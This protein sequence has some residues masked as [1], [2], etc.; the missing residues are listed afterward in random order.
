MRILRYL[1]A[2]IAVLGIGFFLVGVL[3]PRFSYANEVNIN[4]SPA[5]VWAV[6]TD[7]SRTGEW[8]AGFRAIENIR[9]SAL[10]VGSQWRL[11]LVQNG[12]EFE[13]L[14]TV[15]QVTPEKTYAFTLD[16]DVMVASIEVELKPAGQSTQFVATSLVEGKTAAWKSLLWMAKDNMQQQGQANYLALKAL[17]EDGQG[18]TS[19]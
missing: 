3:V 1:F 14:E 18:L 2:V 12:E 7:E 11:R 17:I 19:Q 6:F 4:A 10:E 9:G 13:V 16:A 15:T 8:M 5:E